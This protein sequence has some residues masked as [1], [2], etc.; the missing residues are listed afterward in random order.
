MQK[1][2]TTTVYFSITGCVMIKSFLSLVLIIFDCYFCLSF[3]QNNDVAPVIIIITASS[4]S[5]SVLWSS[6]QSLIRSLDS[7]V[8]DDTL[9]RSAVP[10][11][12]SACL[13][14]N[15]CHFNASP[16][17]VLLQLERRL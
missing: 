16:L 2:T 4:A 14:L 7:W 6:L 12:L 3:C 17:F 13:L 9:Y 11:C 15:A 1:S 10:K 8:I 5:L